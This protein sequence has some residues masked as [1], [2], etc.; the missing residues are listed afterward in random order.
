MDTMLQVNVVAILSHF[1]RSIRSWGVTRA[2]VTGSVG[3]F[4]GRR[5]VTLSGHATGVERTVRSNVC[6]V[7]MKTQALPSGA[8]QGQR[9]SPRIRMATSFLSSTVHAGPGYDSAGLTCRA[10]PAVTNG[11]ERQGLELSEES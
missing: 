9:I 7:F 1:P 11:D 8:L 4:T 3:V 5:V 6:Y 10:L 2:K